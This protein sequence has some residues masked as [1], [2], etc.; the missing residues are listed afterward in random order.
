MGLRRAYFLIVWVLLWPWR[1][2]LGEASVPE[3]A[4]LFRRVLNGEDP[5]RAPPLPRST[6][7]RRPLSLV[8][9]ADWRQ[10]ERR[11]FLVYL[12]QC[13]INLL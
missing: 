13:P 10:L 6:L 11:L 12:R 8:A 4:L 2:S 9:A 5:E 3:P 7:K 1:L